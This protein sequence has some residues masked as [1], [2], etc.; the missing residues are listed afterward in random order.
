MIEPVARANINLLLN[1]QKFKRHTFKFKRGYNSVAEHHS[2]VF[3]VMVLPSAGRYGIMLACWHG[4]PKGRP[5]FPA[6]VQ[7][8]GDLLQDNSLPVSSLLEWPE[9]SKK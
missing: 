7:I 1:I 9:F 2:V 3:V 5:T 4:E 8:L 6:L